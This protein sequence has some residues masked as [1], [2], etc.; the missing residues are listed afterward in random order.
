MFLAFA[1]GIEA[2]GEMFQRLCCA[3]ILGSP[4]LALIEDKVDDA[5]LRQVQ[6]DTTPEVH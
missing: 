6:Q 4:A 2:A 5:L 3:A 1:Q